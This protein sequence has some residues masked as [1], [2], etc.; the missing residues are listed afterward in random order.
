MTTLSAYGLSLEVESLT[1]KGLEYLLAYGF[2]QSIADASAG[3]RAE[4]IKAGKTEAE[5]QVVVD[6][7]RTK[8][9]AAILADEI[10]LR[11]GGGNSGETRL[12]R[13]IRSIGE[14]EVKTRAKT[15]GIALHAPKGTD[16][17]TRAKFA[18]LR[19]GLYDKLF[20]IRCAEWKAEAE[21]RLAATVPTED[22]DL[23]AMLADFGADPA[24]EEEAA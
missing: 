24:D 14:A 21:R 7:A 15:K 8:R 2:K 22:D 12:E 19:K 6:A 1:P 23:D 18:A 9:L 16:D 17:A 3:P 11:I 5:V 4:A 20:T 13:E 10:G